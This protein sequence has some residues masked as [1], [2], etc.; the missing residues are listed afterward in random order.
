MASDNIFFSLKQQQLIFILIRQI[1]P[2]LPPPPL[3]FVC[4]FLLFCLLAC[5]FRFCWYF[6]HN[7]ALPTLTYQDQECVHEFCSLLFYWRKSEAKILLTCCRPRP[8]KSNMQMLNRVSLVSNSEEITSKVYRS[9][10]EVTTRATPH[11]YYYYWSLLYSAVLRSRADSLRSHVILHEW[12]AFYSALF[13]YLSNQPVNGRFGT[14]SAS[15][16]SQ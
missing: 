13:E 2:R 1:Y 8:P 16:T 12:L 6:F 3:F 9:I 11:Y 14:T 5:L 7:W 10:C 4:L 15:T